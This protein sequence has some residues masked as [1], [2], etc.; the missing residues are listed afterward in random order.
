MPRLTVSFCIPT[1]GR[2][3]YLLEA[4][5]S[6]LAQTRPPD[7]VVVSDD[8]G[9]EE[10]RALVSAFARRASFPV[11]YVRCATGPSQADNMNHC[12]REAACDLVLLLHDDDLLMARAVEALARPFEENQAVV[13]AYG[14]QIFIADGGGELRVE[15]ESINHDFRRTATY[16]GLQPDAILSGIW[17]QF[18]NDGYMVKTSVA[19]EVRHKPEYRAGADFD[20]GIRMGERGLFY[21]VDECTAK[22]RNSAESVGRGAGQKSDDSAYHAMRILL[23][24]LETSPH[25]KAEIV[26]TLRNLS[27]MSIRM[28]ANTGRLEEAIPWYFGPYHR[29]RILTLGGIRRGLSLT[30]KWL[31]ERFVRTP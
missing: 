24:L 10:T 2:P 31:K 9:C 21:F 17:Q 6:G 15:S 30:R 23:H 5:E 18:P 19:R 7:E 8:L 13:G 28:A 26:T 22:Y 20:F 14:K 27:P 16:A 29:H 3:R 11:R 1:H 25:Y 12:L 4:L